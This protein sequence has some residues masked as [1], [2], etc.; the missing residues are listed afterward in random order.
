MLKKILIYSLLASSAIYADS[1]NFSS[2]K[3]DNNGNISE[4][5]MKVENTKE[6]IATGYGINKQQALDNAFKSAI[7]QYVGVVIDSETIMKNGTL[8]KD[9]ILTAS[10]GFIKSYKELSSNVDSGLV[11]VEIK[12]VV[13]SQKIFT[14]IKSLK[15]NTV[16]FQSEINGKNIM[17][18][19]S[20][21]LKSKKDSSK[22][23]KKVM[24]NFFS[25]NSIQEMLDIKIIK[26]KVNKDGIKNNQVPINI[27]YTLTLNYDVYIQKT[28]KMEQTFKHLG[29]KLHKRVDLPYFDKRHFLQIQNGAKI[30][31]L[32]STDLGIIKKYGQGYKLD[33]WSFPKEWKDIYPFNSKKRINTKDLFQIVLELKDKNGEIIVANTLKSKNYK[34]LTSNSYGYYNCNFKREQGKILNPFLSKY[35]F[36]SELQLSTTSMVNLENIDKI[37]DISIELE[38]K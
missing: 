13:K 30:K 24:D 3:K 21:K 38:Q 15:I 26:V 5:G 9:N 29:G 25:T 31:K 34:I 17:A 2:I 23:L 14:K 33:V 11:E 18:E 27:D 28:K 20:T 16:S 1:F 32:V 19:I 10:N 4:K 37:K 12:A 22:I 8:I 36:K 7:Q 6:L 35:N